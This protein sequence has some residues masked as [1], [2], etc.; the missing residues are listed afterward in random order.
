MPRLSATPQEFNEMLHPRIDSVQR[1]E[2]RHR[3]G[4]RLAIVKQLSAGL[5][6]FLDLK[7]GK[8]RAFQTD[9]VQPANFVGAVDLHV[10]R[11]IVMDSRRARRRTNIRR[12]VTK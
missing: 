2:F 6:Q 8:P 7:R 3:P 9:V 1:I 10:R 11:H 5:F 12:C 4:E